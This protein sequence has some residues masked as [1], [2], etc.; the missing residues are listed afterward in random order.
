MESGGS[1]SGHG[2]SSISNPG[3]LHPAAGDFTC[4]V[5]GSS[6]THSRLSGCFAETL[7]QSTFPETAAAA[8]VPFRSKHFGNPAPIRPINRFR[9]GRREPHRAGCFHL[10]RLR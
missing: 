2:Q 7:S 3:D 5:P 6:S 9:A 10:F 8:P 1:D 4:L